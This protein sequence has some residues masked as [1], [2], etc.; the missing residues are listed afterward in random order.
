MILEAL[1]IHWRPRRDHASPRV[2]VEG[3][4]MAA[5]EMR[6]CPWTRGALRM[7]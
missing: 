5:I 2:E 1:E 4:E 3:Y 6:R 7:I